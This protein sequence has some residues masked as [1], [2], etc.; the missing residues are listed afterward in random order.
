MK[1]TPEQL[2]EA[3][4]LCT[5]LASVQQRLFRAGLYKTAHAMNQAVKEIGFEV[6]EHYEKARAAISEGE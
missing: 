4:G 6:A 2:T 5:E 1:L 3:F